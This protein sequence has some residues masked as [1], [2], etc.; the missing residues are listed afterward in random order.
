MCVCY[1]YVTHDS[2]FYVF[3][4]KFGNSI[5]YTLQ[6]VPFQI[7]FK[8]DQN[9]PRYVKI[10][11]NFFFSLTFSRLLDYI[12][13]CI[14]PKLVLF[15]IRFY[16]WLP[17]KNFVNIICTISITVNSNIA[18]IFLKFDTFPN[19]FPLL[20]LKV[21]VVYTT[22]AAYTLHLSIRIL[23]WIRMLNMFLA[24]WKIKN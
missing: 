4:L 23:H 7:W 22:T 8:L 2:I 15:F 20:F 14:N 16:S 24:L 13:T 12:K 11:L 6:F 5:R 19:G 18:V 9:F 17:K 1:A 3:K 21:F 10:I